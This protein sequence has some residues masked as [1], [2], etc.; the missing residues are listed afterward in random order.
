M[1]RDKALKYKERAASKEEECAALVK[2]F[3]ELCSVVDND[4]DLSSSNSKS[5]GSSTVSRIKDS[6]MLTPQ[7]FETFLQSVSS[8]SMK[9]NTQTFLADRNALQ[10]K[11]RLC[12]S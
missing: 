9:D 1:Y 6:T 12:M 3:Q 5:L 10:G 2:G 11:K 7:R 4:G 8:P